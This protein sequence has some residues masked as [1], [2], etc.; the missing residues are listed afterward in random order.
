MAAE[1]K[2][3]KELETGTEAPASEKISLSST[4]D[5]TIASSIP[6]APYA[7]IWKDGRK[8]ATVDVRGEISTVNGFAGTVSLGGGHSSAALKAAL[9]ART[10]GGEIRVAGMVADASTLTMRAKLHAAYGS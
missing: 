8:I 2:T 9:F 6:A 1:D 4:N 10:V 3:K 7:E 5:A